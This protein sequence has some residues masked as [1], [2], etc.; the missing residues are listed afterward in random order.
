ML[1]LIL[2]RAGTGKTA[3]VL[4]D[5]RK[6]MDAGESGLLLIVPEQYSHDAE[7]QM[8]A[9]CGD[10]LSLHGETLSFTR[11]CGHVFSETGGA[12]AHMP[13]KGSQILIMHLAIESVAQRLKVFGSKGLRTELL[14]K[15]LDAVKEFKSLRLMPE[16]LDKIAENASSS[17]R[18]KLRDLSLIYSAY[19]ALLQLYG[20]DTADRMTLL[21]E[22]I[23]DSTVGTS[24]HIY[25]DGFNDFTA[26][27]LRIIEELLSKKANLTVCL[28]CDLNDDSEIFKLPRK[29]VGQ[30][31]ALA[32]EYGAEIRVIEDSRDIPCPLTKPPLYAHLTPPVATAAELMFLEKHLF[33]HTA[34]KFAGNCDAIT[35]YA[36]PTRY[37]ECEYAARK[38][39]ELVR[40][41]YRWRD[42]SVM[43]RNWEDYGPICENVFEKYAIPFFSSG[44][45][46]ILEKSP[47]ALIDATLDIAVSGL[48]YKPVFRYLKTGLANISADACSELENYVLKWNI[49]SSMW[50]REWTLPTSGYGGDS[51]KDALSRLNNLRRAVIEPINRFRDGMKGVTGT[52]TKLR[53]LYTFLEDIMLPQRLEE[54]ASDLEI[55]GDTRLA[56][57]YT[58]I[59]DII[60]NTMEQMYELLGETLMSAAEFRKLFT[61][62][63]SQYDIG[64]IPVSLDRTALG[65]MTMSRRRGLKCLI[66]LGA[67]DEDMPKLTKG[68]GALSDNE[69]VEI[70]RLGADMP[71]GLEE[72]LCRE[73]NM[74]YSTLTLPSRELV[75]MYPIG[76]GGRASFIIKRI[77]AMFGI[78]EITLK[79]EEYMSAAIVPCF[80]LAALSGKTNDSLLAL[81]A[82]EYLEKDSSGYLYPDTSFSGQRKLSSSVAKDLYGSKMS[83]S[84][85]RVDKYYSCPF[86]HY[87]QSGLRLSPRI[88]AEFDA[89]TAGIFMHYVLERV[90]REIK[91]TVGFKNVDEPLWQALTSRYIEQFVH[92]VLYDFEGKNARFIYL[93]RRLEDDARCVVLDMLEELK[94]SD[95]EPLDFELDFSKWNK[96]VNTYGNKDVNTYV[97]TA[98]NTYGNTAENTYG[99]T[100]ENTYVNTYGNT[101]GNTSV[102]TSVN[103]SSAYITDM[104]PPISSALS[105][106]PPLHLRGIVDRVDGYK[107]GEKMYIR[108]I[109]YKTGKKSLNLSDV[110][111]GRDMQML[112]YLFTLQNYGSNLYG[113]DIIPAGV[114]YIPARDIVIKA[115]RNV[116]EEEI[117]K[118]REKELR[119]A[120]LILSDPDMIDAM[121][122]GDEKKYLPV[123]YLKDGSATGD[124]LVTSGQ[125][126]LLAAHV[127][128]MLR[129][130]AAEILD[131]SIICKPYY[132]SVSDNAC[133]YCE[134]RTVCA[135][136]EDMGDSRRFV[137][138]MKTAE[139][140]EAINDKR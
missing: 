117:A 131:G 52:D 11:L 116:S 34:A 107:S 77:K 29:T 94:R 103:T 124:S 49:R 41:G 19:D 105:I 67:T 45:A 51:D 16:T 97:N 10:K 12:P 2:G 50:D 127:N 93:F 112:I 38:V 122:N 120:G 55:R 99:N 113:S 82:H 59:W 137:P 36:A 86:Q 48:E 133:I 8:C 118:M 98:E 43:A 26:Q 7:K 129:R 92:D 68:S 18:E 46:D 83:L 100:A 54:K 14:E 33:T 20:G 72:R 60:N 23:G 134:Y 89:P 28:T 87:V 114:L 9:V 47:A 71:S 101:Y 76:G 130:A 25:F 40:V 65:G 37:T 80:E 115:S 75:V 139:V 4:S 3:L 53:A 110:L 108:V 104:A 109:D 136:D 90:A 22:M 121:E 119:R 27:E 66:I 32:R 64:V 132:K 81:A 138:N 17:L 84:A 102:N 61:L 91:A 140:W 95:F 63:L 57:E 78:S 6:R 111:N 62:T 58:Q 96:D 69:R 135:F 31:K 79:E 123:K 15:M 42:I 85:S 24:G 70:C 5:I 56:D 21:A 73:M 35:I 126:V 88:P 13:D 106:P 30:L 125:I 128:N 1:D 44:R 39:W 74:L